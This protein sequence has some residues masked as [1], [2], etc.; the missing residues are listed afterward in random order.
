MTADAT[1]PTRLKLLKMGATQYPHLLDF[2]EVVLVALS[3]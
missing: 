1:G 3:S 2:R